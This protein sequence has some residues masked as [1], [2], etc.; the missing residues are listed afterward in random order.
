MQ[1]IHHK[2]HANKGLTTLIPFDSG[3]TNATNITTAQTHANKGLTTLM[4]SS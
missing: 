3:N 1:V 2:H 4:K